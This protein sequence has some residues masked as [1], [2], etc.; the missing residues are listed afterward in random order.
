L[1]LALTQSV[2]ELTDRYLRGEAESLAAAVLNSLR[3]RWDRERTPLPPFLLEAW[4]R[5]AD[6]LP[7][8]TESPALA[9]TWVELHPGS[10]LLEHLDQDE[11]LRADEWLAVAQVLRSHYPVALARLGFYE[12]DQELL[13]HLI[14]NLTQVSAA[15]SQIRPL[16]QTV[17]D[18]IRSLCPHLDREAASALTVTEL[19][20]ALDAKTWW[21][22][23]DLAT[24]PSSEPAAPGR[25][26]RVDVERV[27]QDL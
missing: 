12:R 9:P 18:R 6:S 13:Q 7:H 21:S 8:V 25:F 1:L 5:L 3:E 10:R 24:P 17:L 20:Q 2:D 4:Y 19:A 11:L 22:P 23:Q 15:N 26:A 16:A 14:V 27:L